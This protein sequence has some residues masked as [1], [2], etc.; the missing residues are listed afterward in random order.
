MPR[1][2]S[3]KIV[4]GENCDI[5]DHTPCDIKVSIAYAAQSA[6]DL[7]LPIYGKIQQIQKSGVTSESAARNTLRTWAKQVNGSAAASQSQKN[8]VAAVLDRNQI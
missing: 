8:M 1:K 3:K 6:R 5:K 4:L 7:N 2:P